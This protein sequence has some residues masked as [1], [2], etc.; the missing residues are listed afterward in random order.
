MNSKLEKI[1]VISTGAKG[2]IRSV[3]ESHLVSDV[4][5][6]YS[7]SWIKSHDDGGVLKRVFIFLFS[8]L[9]FLHT[10]LSGAKIYHLHMSMRGSFARKYIFTKIALFFGAKV[11]IHLHGSEFINFYKNASDWYKKLIEDVFIVA[12]KVI[13]LSAYWKN[14]IEKI[15]PTADVVII[16]NYVIPI[17]E[18]CYL[19]NKCT[20]EKFIF[21]FMGYVGERKGIYDLIS[22]AKLL[23]EAGL[24]F[25]IICGG[26][27]DVD[28][29]REYC[30]KLGV[31]G[32]VEF[33]G[34]VSGD[35]KVELYRE[36][37]VFVL[38]SYNEGLPMAVLEAMSASLPVI[39]TNVGGIPEVIVG[40]VEG[41]IFDAGDVDRL[42]EIMHDFIVNKYSVLDL[43]SNSYYKYSNNF[44]PSMVLPK[45]AKVY[46]SLN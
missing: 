16:N 40:G 41:L 28:K 3:V 46:N 43:A 6:G 33:R 19:K 34:W 30:N 21:L 31:E 22:A 39:S 12:S 7:V 27:G 14:E 4:Y 23:K 45:L 15:S 35:D 29:A 44:S 36:A 18:D 42:V 8:F 9:R 25:R 37:D 11:I 26:N 13:V 17:F 10:L 5:S 24:N 20:D 2:G 38:P 1:V 32:Y